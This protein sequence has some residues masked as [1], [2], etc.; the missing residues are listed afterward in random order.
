MEGR[1]A[2][3]QLMERRRARTQL[4]EVRVCAYTEMP[5]TV[6]V[7]EGTATGTGAADRQTVASGFHPSD[8]PKTRTGSPT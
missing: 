4:E 8:R 1:R 2:R 5:A 7:V 6:S 3:K